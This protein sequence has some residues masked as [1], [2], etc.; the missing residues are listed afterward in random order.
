VIAISTQRHD[1]VEAAHVLARL[2]LVTA[3]GHV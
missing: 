1:L 2:G 3:Y